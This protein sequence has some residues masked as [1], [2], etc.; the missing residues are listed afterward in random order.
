MTQGSVWKPLAVATAGAL[1]VGFCGGMLT[2]I[3]PW[4]QAL[5]KPSWQPPDYLFGPAWT[6]IFILA[7]A[8]AVLVWRN[9]ADHRQRVTI[10]ALFLINACFNVGWST[11]FFALKRPDWALIEVGFLW[12]AILIPMIVFWRISKIASLLLLP[13]LAWV[14]FAS[15]L[16]LTVVRLNA[17]FA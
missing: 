13:Y 15:Y 8:S 11:L 6:T 10:I 14:T 17:P 3:G 16:N 4:Y 5:K 12:L 9:A 7:V 1:T 2:D